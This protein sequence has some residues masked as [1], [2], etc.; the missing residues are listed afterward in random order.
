MSVLPKPA[1]TSAFAVLLATAFAAPA[2][3]QTPEI[4]LGAEARAALSLTVYNQ[5]LALVVETRRAELP[6][7]A[8]R[9]RLTDVSPLLQP[10]SVSLSGPDL[11]VLEFSSHFDL[12]TPYRLLEASL[13]RSVKVAQ[14]NPA[15]GAETIEDARVLSVQDGVVLKIGDRI[16]TG[17]DLPGR[18]IFGEIP[19]GLTETPTLGAL[20][21]S[22]GG[23]TVALSYLTGGL[24]WQA[25]YIARL[26][27]ATGSLAISGLATLTNGSM[28]GYADARLRLVAGTVNRVGGP[29]QPRA[30]ARVAGAMAMADAPE[31]APRG[32]GELYVYDPGRTVSLRPRET[33]QIALLSAGE[34][35]FEQEF[36]LQGLASLLGRGGEI[37]PVKAQTLLR[38]KNEVGAGLGKPLPAGILR[39]YGLG[40]EAPP[41]FL[42]EDRIRHTAEGEQVEV[43]LGQAFDV[44]GEARQTAFEQLAAGSF[45]AAQEVTLRNAKARP[46]TVKVTGDLPPGWK[47]LDQSA[48]HE[49]ETATRVAWTLEVPAGGQTV[50]TYKVRVVRP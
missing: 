4:S 33:K 1:V 5:D 9:L 44:T 22:Q 38:F 3:A 16:E 48:S 50:L 32:E 26:D 34:V 27:E 23:D 45:E 40:G 17:K 49:T 19:A 6:A 10:G 11:R 20:V 25:D 30:R 8:A 13:G 47:I 43:A 31:M 28:T 46:V 35:P 7:G 24:S 15:T 2:P 18:I 12:L 29:I 21:E 14:I 41:L 36:R 37:E 39:A 42:G